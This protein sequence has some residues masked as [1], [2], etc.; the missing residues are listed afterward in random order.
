MRSEST[1][2]EKSF[3]PKEVD[4]L[5]AVTTRLDDEVMLR[6]ALTTGLRRQDVADIE[7][8]NIDLEE[9]KLTFHEHKKNRW[10]TIPLAPATAK[11]IAQYLNT[12]GARGRRRKYLFPIRSRQLYN[13][14]QSLCDRAGV[15]PR[16]FHALRSTCIKLYQRQGW[17]VEETAKLVG[18]TVA[19]VQLHYTT[20]SDAELAE[21]VR[22]K[23]I[24]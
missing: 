15:P 8:R 16:P 10:R 5:L 17:A 20:P 24:L 23:A 11:V 13:R 7:I 19:V 1:I 9:Q 6:L 21:A 2:G 12:L 3:T 14:L 18:D 22:E 4:R